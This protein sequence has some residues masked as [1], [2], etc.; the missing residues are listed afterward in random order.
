MVSTGASV[1]VTLGV[2]RNCHYF[3]SGIGT[4]AVELIYFLY[5]N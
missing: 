4:E 1:E 5:T 3:E 2:N